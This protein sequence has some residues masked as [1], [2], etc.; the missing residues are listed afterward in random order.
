MSTEE[1]V[2]LVMSLLF[3]KNILSFFDN[4]KQA[5][6][7]KAKEEFL[8]LNIKDKNS[9]LKTEIKRLLNIKKPLKNYDRKLLLIKIKKEPKYIKKILF[10]IHKKQIN[11]QTLN[12]QEELVLN[13]F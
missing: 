1:Q 2:I 11:K 10:E 13:I 6:M 3:N 8:S 4:N 9:Y 12:P 7:I 5:K